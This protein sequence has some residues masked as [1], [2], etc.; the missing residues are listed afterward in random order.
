MR[1]FLALLLV[2]G[3]IVSYVVLA[4]QAG[5]SQEIPWPHLVGAL[6]GCVALFVLMRRR[7]TWFGA[8]AL[9]FALLLTAGFS[10]W[11]LVGSAYAERVHR[12]APGEVVA[13][14]ASL[15]LADQDGRPARLLGEGKTVLVLYRG[16]WCP[17]CRQELVQL[18]KHRAEFERRGVRLVASSVD[19]P[20][21]L[22]AM[23]TS[24]G[25]GFPFL[26]DPQ[27][28]LLDL[29]DVRHPSGGH[30]GQDVA[31]SATFIL[32]PDGNVL[33][34]HLAANYRQRPDPADVLAAAQRVELPAPAR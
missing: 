31:Q 7:F 17:F 19:A 29:L 16:Y 10:Y 14:L 18:E 32:G 11:T 8:L 9:A 20:D 15:E 1:T 34:R 23:R 28:R 26:S 21:K 4:T 27:G 22:A 30:E 3:S 25:A 2:L 33:W 6:A 24:A 5:I 12:A 13:E